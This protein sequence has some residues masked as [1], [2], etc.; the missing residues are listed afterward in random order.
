MRT[1]ARTFG[2]LESGNVDMVPAGLTE[3]TT[4][5]LQNDLGIEIRRGVSYSGTALTFNLRRAP[6][7]DPA[8]RR[9]VSRSLDLDRLAEGVGQ[10]RPA[11]AGF[12]HPASPWAPASDLHRTDQAAARRLMERLGRPPIEV[13]APDNNVV[14]LEAGR[15]VVNALRRIGAD[16]TLS[17]VSRGT[18][19][20]ALGGEGRA[21]VF[22]AAV[23]GIPA[24]AS[25]D[26]NYLRTSFGSRAELNETGYRSGEFDRLAERVAAAPARGPRRRAVAAELRTLARDVP[27]I[28][29]VFS[30][31][32]F[33]YR[34][35]VYNGW[36][37]VKGAGILDKRSFLSGQRGAAARLPEVEAPSESDDGFPLGG[38]GLA[39]AALGFVAVALG[40]AA[41]SRRRT[42]VS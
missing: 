9:A 35:S 31:G 23:T 24:L 20:R 3:T 42:G 41:L 25:Y 1:S 10:V 4:D 30:S 5:R 13:L 39:A 36:V 32:A 7:D 15:Q 27:A 40:A 33:A 14:R 18:L 19:E 28:P 17:E 16:A 22:Q 37:F 8:L 2:A 26:P 29:L 21:P 12:L 38:F 6:F 34:P 11:K